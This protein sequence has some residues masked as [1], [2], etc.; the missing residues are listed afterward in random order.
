MGKQT[1]PQRRT[2]EVTFEEFCERVSE[3]QKADLLDG[4]IY[5]ASPE[6]LDANKLFFWLAWVL[7][8]YAEELGLG[9]IYGSRVAF[10]LDE[11]N[12]PEPDLAFVRK[13][14]LGGERRGY[15]NGAPDVAIEIVSPESVQRDYRDKRDK[16][17]ASG[18]GEYWILDEH[19]Q[20]AIFLRR[21]ASGKFRE[22]KLRKG[23]F[24]SEAF[25]GFWFRPEWL[26]EEP[27]PRRAQ[28]LE[29]ILSRPFNQ[30][31][32]IGGQQ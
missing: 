16:Y 17:E 5:I 14:R 2:G 25:P 18:V 23:E 7:S 32:N 1:V 6:N 8:G 30:S 10:R 27:R 22:V 4:V 3:G 9:E 15:F 24:H 28:I 29:A 21:G 20:V 31:A 19:E 11:N 12:S 26:W 13:E